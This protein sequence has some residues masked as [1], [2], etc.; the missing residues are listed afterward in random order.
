LIKQLLKH[1]PPME[2]PLKEM[3]HWSIDVQIYLGF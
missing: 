3:M 1:E 2:E